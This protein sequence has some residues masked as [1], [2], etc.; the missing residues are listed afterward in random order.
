MDNR[1]TALLGSFC[2]TVMLANIYFMVTSEGPINLGIFGTRLLISAG[3]GA[4]VGAIALAI[5]HFM[6]K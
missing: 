5:A 1:V 6:R 4:V 2:G 3:I